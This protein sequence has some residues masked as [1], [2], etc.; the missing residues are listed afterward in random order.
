MSNRFYSFNIPKSNKVYNPI[1]SFIQALVIVLLFAFIVDYVTLPAYNIHNSGFLFLLVFYL[2]IFGTLYATFSHRFDL[3]VKGTYLLATVIVIATFILSFLSSE[4]LNASKYR[5]QITIKE[6]EEFSA[7][8]DAIKLNKIPLVDQ[9]TAAQLGDKQIGRVQGLGSQYDISNEYML[10]NVNDSVY[11]VSSLEYQD[12]Y[13]WIQ[14]REVGIPS[15]V[16]VNVNDPSDVQLV[17][18]AFGMKYAPSAFFNED[19][20]RH[21]RFSYRTEIFES[22]NFEI[23]DMGNPF[24]IVTV[25]EPS[26][27]WFGGWDT[28]AI[29]V[30]DAVS[31]EMNKYAVEDAPSWVDHIQSANLAWYQIDNWGYYIN[32]WF[33]T[34]FGQKEMIQ[35]TDGYNF[36]SIDEQIYI[37]SGLTSVGSDRSIVGFALINLRTKEATYIKVGGADEY[38]AMNSAIGQVQHL[39]Y[40]STFPLLLNIEGLPTYFMALKDNEGL[41]KLYAMVSVQDYSVVG[42]AATVELTQSSYVEQLMEKGLITGVVLTQNEM[43]GTISTIVSTIINGTTHYYFTLEGSNILYTASSDLSVELA[44]SQVLDPVKIQVTK[45]SDNIMNVITYD[46]LN[47]D[48]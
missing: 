26:I 11:R 38:S 42:V 20:L 37:F 32:G 45:L 9:N 43:V 13:K 15:Y 1:Q 28:E 10:I 23:D 29:I 7:E 31:G 35:T 12:F 39:N 41:V 14:N 34:L 2:L 8:F 33:N 16:S 18:L 27:G 44:L 5:D 46:N 22:M 21:V 30:V 36:V 40:T 47:Y 3:I 48:Y 19:L 6:S 4:F 25:K 17:D 24:Y